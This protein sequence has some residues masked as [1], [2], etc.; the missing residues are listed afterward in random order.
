MDTQVFTVYIRF[1][2]IQKLIFYLLRDINY[3]LHQTETKGHFNLQR[4]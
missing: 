4:F 2:I 3:L 1:R